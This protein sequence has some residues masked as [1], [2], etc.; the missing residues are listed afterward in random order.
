MNSLIWEPYFPVVPTLLAL[1]GLLIVFIVVERRKRQRFPILR[2]A[3]LT[4]MGV[5]VLGLLLRPSTITTASHRSAILLTEGFDATTADSVLL[6]TPGA[7]VYRTTDA[8]PFR[9]AREMRSSREIVDMASQVTHIIGRGM[10]P[11][12]MEQSDAWRYTFLPAEAPEGVVALQYPQR[13]YANRRNRVS[14]QYWVKDTTAIVRLT[15]PLGAED[16]VH[17]KGPGVIPFTLTFYPKTAGTFTY[18]IEGSS[19]SEPLFLDIL[20]EQKLNVLLLNTFPTFEQRYLKNTLAGRGHAIAQRST[21]SRGKQRVEFANQPAYS[22]APLTKE[23]LAK[24]DLVILDGGVY[25]TL[26]SYE[27]RLLRDAVY[28]GMGILFLPDGTERKQT[29]LIK[30][31]PVKGTDTVRISIANTGTYTLPIVP[32]EPVMPGEIL[33]RSKDNRVA[34]GYEALGAGKIGYVTLHETYQLG[35]QAH[36]DAYNELW[37]PIIERLAREERQPHE[38]VIRTPFPWYE[39]E[40]VDFGIVS[41]TADIPAVTVDSMRVPIIED[42]HVGQ[43]WS[44]TMWLAGANWHRVEA[45]GHTTKLHL[46]PA[47]SWK[48]LRIANQVK[49]TTNAQR[50]QQ[51]DRTTGEK[52][53]Q[54]I[55]PAMLFILFVL[56][57]GLLWVTPKL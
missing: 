19:T 41:A 36:G 6:A 51:G 44:G 10:P 50:A 28:D 18:T 29:T 4:V 33:L 45:G 15:G 49:A 34:A 30:W 11:Y 52:R 38:L 16:S 48:S 20:P 2:M 42:P 39:D 7:E 40:P 5:A 57:A 24:N 22:V 17:L 26:S 37:M 47:G 56:S 31:K 43:L 46:A 21:V 32:A 23:V 13:Y 54:G 3:C 9:N 1:L 14:G 25:V 55:V 53:T 12:I 27:Q 35:L 8:A